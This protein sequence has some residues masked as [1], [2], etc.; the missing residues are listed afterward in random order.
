MSRR[1]GTGSAEDRGGQRET[2]T[3]GHPTDWYADAEQR[4][5]EIKRR[6]EKI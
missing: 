5:N 4:P 3:Y 1:G 2:L 6:L